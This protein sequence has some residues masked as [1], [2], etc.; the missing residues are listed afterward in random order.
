[1]N[2]E[3]FAPWERGFDSERAL[4]NDESRQGEY[5]IKRRPT[6]QP[7]PN[8]PH[9]KPVPQ[10]LI[11]R[12]RCQWLLAHGKKVRVP[13][14]LAHKIVVNKNGFNVYLFSDRQLVS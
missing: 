10:T 14:S 11:L 12:T 5:T 13:D 4:R 2:K 7:D 6:S 3:A 9:S 1:V 8:L